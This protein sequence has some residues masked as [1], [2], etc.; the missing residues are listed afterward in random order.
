MFNGQAQRDV[1]TAAL[2]LFNALDR[3]VNEELD[4]LDELLT[5]LENARPPQ[6]RGPE[7]R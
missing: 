4:T 7:D 1:E 5:R 3:L 6:E 2:A